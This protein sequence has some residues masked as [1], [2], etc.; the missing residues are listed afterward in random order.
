MVIKTIIFDLDDTLLDQKKLREL[1]FNQSIGLMINKGLNCTLEQGVAKAKEI[2]N[3]NPVANVYLEVAKY[4]EYSGDKEEIA[5]EAREVHINA[6][7]DKLEPYPE[8]KE[9]LEKLKQKKLDLVL[10]TEG[11]LP[12]QNKKI[13]TLEIREYFDEIFITIT[14]K[15]ELFKEILNKNNLSKNEVLVIGDRLDKEIIAGNRL[16]I[17]TIRVK[18]GKYKEIMPNLEIEKPSY[19]INDLRDIFEII[20]KID[21]EENFNNLQRTEEKSKDL[22]CSDQISEEHSPKEDKLKSTNNIK[23]N[24]NNLK[25]VTIGGGTG[26]SALLEGLKEYT[27]NL[28]SIVTVTDSGRSTGV[29]RKELDMPAPGD[30]RNCLLALANSEKMMYEL[31]QYRFENGSLKGHSFG[32]LFI[33]ALTKL[34]GS[35]EKAIEEASKILNLKGKVLPA[36]FDNIN[37]CAELEDGNIL[38][39][40]DKIIDRHNNYVYLRPRI[41]RVF[42][43]PEAKVNEK[44]IEKIK[45]ADL[46]IISPGSL[47]TSIISNLIIKGIPEAIK[48]SK[49]KKVYVCNIMTQVSQTYGFKASDHVCQILKYLGNK[50]QLDFVILNNGK[51]SD[52]LLESYEKENAF[53]VENDIEEVKKF[54]KKVLIGD[55]LDDVK[56][57]KLLWEKKDLLRHNPR[58]IAGALVGVVEE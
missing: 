24:K 14:E 53:L 37:I 46:I 33:A 48:D 54:A 5:K 40:E 26:T 47:F 6:K 42:H 15:T 43:K 28:T 11:S 16:G 52:S 7:F 32:N 50:F 49:A 38:E 1:A 29:I 21:N 12:Q 8:V 20:E 30:T 55:F 23:F 13:D 17:K 57:K 9:V 44:V 36:T 27:D 19:E 25:I 56:E 10:V 22:G 45:E 3:N 31:F 34:T 51:P 35:F 39:E 58:R 18:R 41:K 2:F 4:F